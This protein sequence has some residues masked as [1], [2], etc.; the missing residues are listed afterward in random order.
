MTLPHLGLDYLA[1]DQCA[2]PFQWIVFGDVAEAIGTGGLVR[3]RPV[4]LVAEATFNLDP[5]CQNAAL[6]SI[7]VVPGVGNSVRLAEI[8][9]LLR[10]G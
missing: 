2:V 8:R 5:R 1:S 3:V 4:F 9:S 10:S 6:D 7:L